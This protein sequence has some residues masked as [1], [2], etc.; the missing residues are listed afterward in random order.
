MCCCACVSCVLAAA[1]CRAVQRASTWQ[2]SQQSV[3]L[4]EADGPVPAARLTRSAVATEHS[5]PLA[6]VTRQ[7]LPLPALH[8]GSMFL[9]IELS[10]WLT[11]GAARVWDDRR[12]ML[13]LCAVCAN[14]RHRSELQ[15]PQLPRARGRT[16]ACKLRRLERNE[17]SL[18]PRRAKRRPSLSR[19]REV[20]TRL[21]RRR[22]RAWPS[23]RSRSRRSGLRS[24]R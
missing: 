12:C 21:T 19:G 23:R 11:A 13:L 3:L 20:R 8:I 16:P 2:R 4:L 22:R 6:C 7:R 1:F 5:C 24:A 15:R 14:S 17:G 10:V 18:Q 9:T